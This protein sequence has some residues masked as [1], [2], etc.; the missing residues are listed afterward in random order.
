MPSQ[1]ENFR[2]STAASIGVAIRHYRKR[3]GLTQTELAEQVGL[4][5]TYLSSLEQ[6]RVSDQVLRLLRVLNKL[7]VQVVLEEGRHHDR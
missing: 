6:G 2:I 1:R 4:N 5:R 3:A 7:D